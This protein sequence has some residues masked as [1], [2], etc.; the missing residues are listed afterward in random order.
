MF[1]RTRAELD[2]LNNI[3]LRDKIQEYRALQNSLGPSNLRVYVRFVT[4]GL[5]VGLSGEFNQELAVIRSDYGSDT[6][7]HSSVEALGCDELVDLSKAQ[8]RH[9]RS[10]DA[11]IRIRYDANNPSLIKH[12][13][14]GLKGLVVS[15]PAAE[16]ARLVNDNPDGAIFDLNIR[17][18]LGA[19]GG[20]NR[21]IQAS[22]TDLGLS[23]QFW[24]LNNGITIA[25]DHCDPIT[26]PDNPM[27]KLRNLQIVNGCQTATTLALAQREG[28]LAADARVLARIYETSD[29]KFVGR[30]VLTTNNQN[31]I[32][33]RDLRA[34]EPVQLDMEA[35]FRIYDYWYERKPRQFDT[36]DLIGTWYHHL[37]FPATPQHAGSRRLRVSRRRCVQPC[38]L[39]VRKAERGDGQDV[40]EPLGG[41]GAGDRCDDGRG[42]VESGA[43]ALD[44]RAHRPDHQSLL[45][46]LT[47]PP[48]ALP[49]LEMRRGIG[50]P[51]ATIRCVHPTGDPPPG[52]FLGRGRALDS[53][54]ERKWPAAVH[55]RSRASS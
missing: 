47:G 21:D 30:I 42:R 34:N 26:D 23:Y 44:R 45:R 37:T 15:V 38:H 52:G 43:R 20:V 12:Y 24:F 41:A 13:A 9:D 49:W 17:R 32:T 2:T 33:G 51:R 36:A 40:R 25:C 48:T 35:A 19:R 46:V 50:V 27:I 4:N 7:E 14:Q 18:F 3:A 6:F 22:C 55:S 31:Q 5:T 1:Q 54:G 10:V 28:R 39:V 8:D 53:K 29:P 16:I 11:D